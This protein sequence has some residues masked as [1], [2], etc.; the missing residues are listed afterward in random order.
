MTSEA[1]G[2]IERIFKALI[3]VPIM[4]LVGWWIFSNY[5]DKTLSLKQASIGYLLLGIAFILG[6]I[7]IVA[8]GWGFLGILAL[9]YIPLLAL[10]CW[11][12]I[13]LQKV[14]QQ[15][16]REEISKYELAIERDPKNAAAFSFLGQTYLKL[17]KYDEAV[18]ALEKAVEMDP[19]ARYDKIYL[20]D[21]REYQAYVC[22]HQRK[23]G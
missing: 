18:A 8:G 9:V 17:G 16:L 5:L 23:R 4:T 3:F 6:V 21:A 15:H 13:Y 19:D 22:R 10:A 14:Q 20:R 1:I 2:I 12:Y 11:E 7:S